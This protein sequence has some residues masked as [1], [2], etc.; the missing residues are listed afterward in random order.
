MSNETY[1]LNRQLAAAF[2][3]PQRCRRAVLT[4]EAGELPRWELEVYATDVIRAGS[5]ATQKDAAIA[6]LHIPFVLRLATAGGSE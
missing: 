2:G 3:L 6:V 1:L 4:L 5:L